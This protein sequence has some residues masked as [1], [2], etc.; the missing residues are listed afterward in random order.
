MKKNSKIKFL[1]L[2]LITIIIGYLVGFIYNN[3]RLI[4]NKNDIGINNISLDNIK[5]D[6]FKLENDKLISE[7]NTPK[8]I[9]ENQNFQYLKKLKFNYTASKNFE[10]TINENYANVYGLEK[11]VNLTGHNNKNIN[12]F[13]EDLSR[14]I[15][16]LEI[17]FTLDDTLEISNIQIDN[18]IVYMALNYSYF[19]LGAITIFLCIYFRKSLSN[20]IEYL[21]LILGLFFGITLIINT[22]IA[23]GK[24]WDEQIHYDYTY[25]L[26]NKYFTEAAY[27]LSD[28]DLQFVKNA[29]SYFNT[30]E[31]K[32]AFIEH[33]NNVNKQAT[34]YKTNVKFGFNKVSYLPASLVF[35]LGNTLKLPF[36]LMYISAL[37]INL[38]VYVGIVFLAIKKTPIGK[39]LM[40]VIGLIPTTLFMACSFSYDPP[41]TAFVL[42]GLA[43]Y[44]Y[45][46]KN[47]ETKLDMSSALIMAT[48]FTLG[49]MSKPVY[50]FLLLLFLTLPKSKFKSSKKKNQFLLMTFI[51]LLMTL[52]LIIMPVLAHVDVSDA[53]GGD[54]NAT[55][56]VLTILKSPISFVRVFFDN[57]GLSFLSKFISPSTL[58]SFGYFNQISENSTNIYYLFLALLFGSVF[59]KNENLLDKKSKIIL[60]I[61]IFLSIGC[62]WGS[63]YVS[64]TPVG[65]TTINGVQN[66]YFIP[67][68]M[69]LLL[70][71]MTNNVKVN[72]NDKKI[73]AIYTVILFI[74]ISMTLFYKFI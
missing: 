26:A 66:R 44:L 61:L 63:L 29:F 13:V 5:L 51:I 47:K 53:R 49:T 71:L 24:S 20:H 45:E 38:F 55:L 2:F 48:S 40:L 69:P 70:L 10:W 17:S 3:Y 46:M 19:L 22:Q 41:I 15:S 4:R 65:S 58:L 23:C 60:G 16:K 35:L 59:I 39:Y 30:D 42:L 7:N 25:G 74:V 9:I 14:N 57:A 33:L 54:T 56:Q 32:K 43:Y 31:E 27:E 73:Y 21:F 6:G 37:F 36:N 50:A 52:F 62:I 11:N 8:I 34:T 72:L 67:L 28:N 68:I 64:F 18:S 1:V 12:I